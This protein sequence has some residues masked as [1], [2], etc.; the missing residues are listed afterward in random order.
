M[1]FTA[2]RIGNYSVTSI[3]SVTGGKRGS[4]Y[5]QF[6]SMFVTQPLRWDQIAAGQLSAAKFASA[7]SSNNSGSFSG[8]YLAFEFQD[9]ST[10]GSP[11]RY[12]WAGLSVANGDI[13]SPSANFPRLTVSN[14]AYDNTGAQIPM[15]AT[16]SVPEPSSIALLALGALTLGARGVRSWRRNRAAASQS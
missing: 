15:G 8:V 2:H 9:S 6:K 3:R 13:T 5:L 7:I 4:G 16:V 10:V 1:G 14:W 11:M 12:G